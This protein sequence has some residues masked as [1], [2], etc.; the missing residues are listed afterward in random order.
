ML[1]DLF[2][3]APFPLC[4]FEEEA[5]GNLEVPKLKK[6]QGDSYNYTCSIQNFN[7]T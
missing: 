5:T 2:K 6:L 1:E 3:F 7:A 4:D